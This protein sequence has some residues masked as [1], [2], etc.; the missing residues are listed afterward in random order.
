MRDRI[1][2]GSAVA[3]MTTSLTALP[4]LAADD[5]EDDQYCPS[6]YNASAYSRTVSNAYQNHYYSD[7]HSD[8]IWSR[9]TQSY[10]HATESPFND[11]YISG[12]TRSTYEVW[13]TNCL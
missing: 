3:L 4:A 7:F 8:E 13:S 11:S 1:L 9:S 5:R 12:Y 6:G 10:I 2:A